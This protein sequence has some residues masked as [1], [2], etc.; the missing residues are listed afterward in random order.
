MFKA[1]SRGILPPRPYLALKERFQNNLWVS[2]GESRAYIWHRS[3]R[4]SNAY[5][6]LL[7]PSFFKKRRKNFQH[8]YI[9]LSAHRLLQTQYHRN[10]RTAFH[11]RGEHIDNS[12]C[13]LDDL[14]QLMYLMLSMSIFMWYASPSIMTACLSAAWIPA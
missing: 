11:T 8:R 7:W 2:F 6:Q 12:T 10:L 13:H 4:P 9:W 5:V 1:R 3:V 14:M